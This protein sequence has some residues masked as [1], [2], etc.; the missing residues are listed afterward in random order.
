[1]RTTVPLTGYVHQS[2]VLS[3]SRSPNYSRVKRAS[4]EQEPSRCLAD[5]AAP[6]LC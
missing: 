1:M 6:Q 5:V 2:P 4:L 3:H